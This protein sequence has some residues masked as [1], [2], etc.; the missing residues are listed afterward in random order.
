MIADYFLNQFK[1]TLITQFHVTAEAVE[2]VF[3][4]YLDLHLPM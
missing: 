2:V 1:C 3:V 4:W